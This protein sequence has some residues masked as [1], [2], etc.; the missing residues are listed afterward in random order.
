M[1]T[2][3]ATTNTNVDGDK[4]DKTRIK[5]PNKL[6][7]YR[8]SN[9]ATTTT[10]YYKNKFSTVST[11][12]FYPLVNLINE[13]LKSHGQQQIQPQ[14]LQQQGKL[15]INQI[16]RKEME[17]DDLD[18]LLLSQSLVVLG[19]FCR[20]SIHTMIQKQ[21][22]LETF[23]YAFL[24]KEFYSL[25]IRR[26]SMSALLA[27]TECLVLLLDNTTNGNSN[28]HFQK[29]DYSPIECL[30]DIN[31]LSAS[32]INDNSSGNSSLYGYDKQVDPEI[33]EILFKLIEWIEVTFHT[34]VDNTLK[35]LKTETM[36]N[37]IAIFEIYK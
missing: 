7:Q 31:L 35:I 24:C 23:Q 28:H 16:E 15:N 8:Q 14:Q 13:S 10:R 19:I 2:A 4:N 11:L 36:K 32:T 27:C 17:M 3:T 37:I 33:M 22:I 34:E 21:Y 12:F 25:S 30:K 1:A 26:A 9:T 5:R 6:K 29:Y 20:C 18:S